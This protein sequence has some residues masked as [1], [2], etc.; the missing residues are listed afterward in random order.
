LLRVGRAEENIRSPRRTT[1]GGHRPH[2]LAARRLDWII[3]AGES[4]GKTAS[5]HQ[6]GVGAEDLMNPVSQG[7]DSVFLKQVGAVALAG[8][9]VK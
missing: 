5:I 8:G 3:Q 2:A 9:T 1:E 4:G 7:R 6:L